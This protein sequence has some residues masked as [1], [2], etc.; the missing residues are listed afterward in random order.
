MREAGPRLSVPPELAAAIM[1]HF[2]K[3]NARR[4]KNILPAETRFLR[5]RNRC[6]TRM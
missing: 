5:R 1:K 3:S 6:W 2:E 4:R